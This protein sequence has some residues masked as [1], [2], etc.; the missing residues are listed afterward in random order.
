MRKSFLI[1]LIVLGFTVSVFS[2][3]RSREWSRVRAAHL[4]LHSECAVCGISS[5]LQVH[6]IKP[7]HLDPSLELD[8]DNLITLCTSKNWVFNCHFLVGHCSNFRYENPWILEDIE[9]I[10]VVGDPHYIELNGYQ[11]FE[12][13]RRFML[14]RARVYN[15]Q[16]YGICNRRFTK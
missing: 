8:S 6:H 11:E 12:S 14:Q 7:F 13:Y 9:K 3:E 4:V 16:K 15:C 10:K 5:D 2:A 1:F